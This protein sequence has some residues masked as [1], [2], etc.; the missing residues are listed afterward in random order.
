MQ[1]RLDA[2]G[3]EGL[4]PATYMEDLTLGHRQL[5]EIARAMG[6]KA[7][8]FI[9]DEPT[10]TLNATDIAHVFSAIRRVTAQG[11]AVI[12]VSHRLDEVLAL[13]HRIVVMRDGAVVAEK[14]AADVT[15]ESLVATDARP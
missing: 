14:P 5:V 12:Y 13:C 3:L 15:G 11:C 2:V 8:L 9:L 6:R 7:Q 1:A 10:A 4:D